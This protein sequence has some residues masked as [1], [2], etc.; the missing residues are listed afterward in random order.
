MSKTRGEEGKKER[1]ALARCAVRRSVTPEEITWT[2]FPPKIRNSQKF[3]EEGGRT[4]AEKQRKRIAR[5]PTHLLQDEKCEDITNLLRSATPR[6]HKM[7]NA[8]GA[9]RAMMV[10]KKSSGHAGQK[11]RLWEA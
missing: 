11:R 4:H 3:K 5:L 9:K 2:R 10:W 1:P 6:R 7:G 8:A